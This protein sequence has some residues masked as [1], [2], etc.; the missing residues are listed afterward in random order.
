MRRYVWDVTYTAETYID[1]LDTFS[2]HRSMEP[3][4]RQ[5]LYDRIRRRIESRSGGVVRKSHLALLH[6]ARRL[7]AD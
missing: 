2:G 4:K 7:P 3:A 5:E 6:V 1:V